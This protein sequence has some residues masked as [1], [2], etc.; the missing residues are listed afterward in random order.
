[1]L[2]VENSDMDSCFVSVGYE[3]TY[4]MRDGPIF[5]KERLTRRAIERA[6][7]LGHAMRFVHVEA[8]KESDRGDTTSVSHSKFMWFLII[9]GN[10]RVMSVKFMSPP[11]IFR[12]NLIGI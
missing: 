3:L 2:P 5:V 12:G 8:S 1:M 4:S 11:K 10:F 9:R 6:R 7:Q